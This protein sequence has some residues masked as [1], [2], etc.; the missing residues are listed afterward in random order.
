M[1]ATQP[2]HYWLQE[3]SGLPMLLSNA[4]PH[5][6]ILQPNPS[7]IYINLIQCWNDFRGTERE[8][9]ILPASNW[10]GNISENQRGK[11]NNKKS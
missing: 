8:R 4:P 3:E 1:R 7:L 11:N 10:G 6:L 2:E 9:G 5:P